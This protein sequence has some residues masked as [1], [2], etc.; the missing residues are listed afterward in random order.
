LFEQFK[1]AESLSQRDDLEEEITG[2][3]LFIKE[4]LRNHPN[5]E[6]QF[7]AEALLELDRK[8]KSNANKRLALESFFVKIKP[9]FRS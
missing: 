1:L 8:L 5:Q 3:L 2:W 4:E 9:L 6:N 7:L